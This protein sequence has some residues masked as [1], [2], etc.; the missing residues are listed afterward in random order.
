MTNAAEQMDTLELPDVPT[1]SSMIL[2]VDE[3]IAQTMEAIEQYG[4]W[5]EGQRRRLS[6][7]RKLR[8]IALQM[9]RLETN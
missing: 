9:G 7:L 4:N 2:V 5:L 3:A 8:E 6:H 1:P